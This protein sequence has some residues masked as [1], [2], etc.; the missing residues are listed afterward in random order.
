LE[1]PFDTAFADFRDPVRLNA[2]ALRARAFGFFGKGCIHPDQIAVV[3]AVFTPTESDVAQA[4]RVVTAFDEA[5]R[6]GKAAIQVEGRMVD[7]PVASK[8]RRL[9]E[10]AGLIRQ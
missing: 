3:N 9:L 10:R 4:R 5:E 1:Q 8:A 2:D 7:Y 6:K